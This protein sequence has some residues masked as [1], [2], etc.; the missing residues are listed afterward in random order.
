MFARLL[1]SESLR[2]AIG[3]GF[4][5]VGYAVANIVL[6]KVLS[7]ASFGVVTLVLALS[8]FG[9]T[10]GPC[11]LEIVA[12][13]HRPRASHRFAMLVLTMAVITGVMVAAIAGLYY[14]LPGSLV[15]LV[16]AAV[17][18]TATNRVGAALFQGERR[19]PMALGL[20]QVHN[21][22]LLGAALWAF[23]MPGT[24]ENVV[25]SM[26]TAGYLLSAMFG[27]WL[28]LRSVNSGRVE[29]D[30]RMA[31]KEG[32][33]AMGLGVAVQLLMQFERL[34]IP[35]LGS[36]EMLSTY[37]VL[38]AT[39]GSPF[40]MLQIG[41]SFSLLPPLRS[42][43]TWAAARGV[44]LREAATSLVVA[45]IAGAAI[46]LASPLIFEVVLGGKYPIDSG[47]IVASLAIGL[48]KLWEGFSTTVVSACG[49]ANAMALIS[50]HAWI[51]L[52]TA[53]VGAIV[54]SRFGLLGILWGVG[55][56]WILL[57][58]GGTYLALI[59]VRQRFAMTPTVAG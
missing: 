51:C 12:N 25:V 44:L 1:K 32:F 29:I 6:A 42:A 52:G 36:L 49:S 3:F 46:V 50:A 9:L 18:G 23:T 28:A 27:W 45:L 57:A 30:R 2:S 34:A 40:R 16:L 19:L 21:Y 35:K 17:V 8:Q 54:G 38:A 10:L 55:L 4:G 15:I 48:A 7:P 41:T 14:H 37:A 59:S 43:K 39:I 53:T 58:A 56:G 31:L 33:A 5:G 11:G 22:V 24:G 13:R 47:L 26:V 20:T